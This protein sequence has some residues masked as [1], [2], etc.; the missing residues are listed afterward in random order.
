MSS[1]TWELHFENHCPRVSILENQ[2]KIFNITM[3]TN[4]VVSYKSI[5]H[6]RNFKINTSFLFTGLMSLLPF[7]FQV[8]LSVF[9]SGV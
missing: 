1:Q 9:L 3:K 4:I 2:L 7:I 5:K 6:I 8:V